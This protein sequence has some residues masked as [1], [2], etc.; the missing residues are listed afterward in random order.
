MVATITTQPRIDRSTVTTSGELSH[1]AN[2]S[3]RTRG[4]TSTIT[5]S[6]A[7]LFGICAISTPSTF[8]QFDA[9]R[10]PGYSSCGA[11]AR[12]RAHSFA[13]RRSL[14]RRP[15]A[16][17]GIAHNGPLFRRLSA[18][19][20]SPAVELPAAL[21][22]LGCGPVR[23][24]AIFQPVDGRPGI[25]AQRTTQAASYGAALRRWAR[26]VDRQAARGPIRLCSYATRACTRAYLTRA[27]R[28]SR[29][30]VEPVPPDACSR[31]RTTRF[32]PFARGS[33]APIGAYWCR[34]GRASISPAVW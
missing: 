9:P 19:R 25:A 30:R 28:G 1:T 26:H 21:F 7:A 15:S 4:E 13:L 31:A 5:P 14:R 27:A 6:C 3:T 10:A 23:S 22:A 17:L 34:K 24:P 18:A 2:T 8:P 32:A 29:T 16:A 11:R 12:L 20:R 33:S